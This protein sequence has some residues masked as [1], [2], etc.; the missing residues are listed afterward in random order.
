MKWAEVLLHDKPQRTSSIYVFWPSLRTYLMSDCRVDG[1]GVLVPP[2]HK[3]TLRVARTTEEVEELLPTWANW[4]DHPSLDGEVW[5]AQIR[6]E[7]GKLEP[8]V[9]VLYR[10]GR[11]ECLL[12]GTLAVDHMHLSFGGVRLLLPKARLIRIQT[13]AFLGNRTEENSRLIVG[14]LLKALERKDADSVE[15]SSLRTDSPL[16]GWA[17]ILPGLLSRD[18]FPPQMSHFSL[19]PPSN[20]QEFLCGLSKKKRRNY[21]RCSEKLMR[22][23]PGQI[24]LR[25]FQRKPDLDALLR[26]CDQIAGKT[27]QRRLKTGFVNDEATQSLMRTY[28]AKSMLWGYVLDIAGQPSAF[29]I[30][31][32]HCETAYPL[33]MGYDPKFHNFSLGF[34]L[35]MQYVREVCSTST[36][37]RVDF[38]HGNHRYKREICNEEWHAAAVSIFAPY[39]KWIAVNMLRTALALTR[40]AAMRVMRS[41][42]LH[43]TS[44]RTWRRIVL[45][46]RT[47]MRQAA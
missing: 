30:G 7:A 28:H 3:M 29:I 31:V 21:A 37:K 9:V 20:F 1:K 8:Y 35:L 11:P 40:H 24:R 15:F 23:F 26:D 33:F 5:L 34:L 2:Q 44:V 13:N 47:W 6:H 25:S 16:Y 14:E 41:P 39:P 17:R 43:D 46:K 10:D 4:C 27:Y 45:A 38:G 12:A 42:R 36:V 22:A 32:T 19:L 18:Y